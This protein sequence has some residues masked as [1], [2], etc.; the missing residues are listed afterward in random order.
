MLL[1]MVGAEHR[2][3]TPLPAVKACGIF[4]WAEPST[5]PSGGCRDD[6]AHILG[7][8]YVCYRANRLGWKAVRVNM[9]GHLRR[10][11]H[12]S[13]VR[14]SVGSG[15]GKP[16]TRRGACVLPGFPHTEV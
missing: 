6:T 15:L 8:H 9:T 1:P 13:L 12:F 7:N 14:G 3:M 16:R 10:K 4:G 2:M 11:S 5:S